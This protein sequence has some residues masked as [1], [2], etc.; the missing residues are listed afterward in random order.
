MYLPPV[1]DA[2]GNGFNDFFE[3]SQGLANTVTSGRY[4][5]VISAGDITA[6]WSRPA[7]S[8]DG[9]CILNFNDDTYVDFGDYTCPF[10]V[11]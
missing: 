5:T 11:I 9:T 3:V 1:A 4:T 10:E 2:N 8:K 6:T 7:G